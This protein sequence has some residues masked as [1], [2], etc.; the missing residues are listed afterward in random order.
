[1]KSKLLRKVKNLLNLIKKYLSN[2]FFC[3]SHIVSFMN[4]PEADDEEI[5]TSYDAQIQ[6]LT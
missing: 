3:Q 5:N 2:I 4:Q 6:V 1:M